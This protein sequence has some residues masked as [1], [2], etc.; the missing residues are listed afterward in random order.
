MTA[1]LEEAA[2]RAMAALPAD[3][4]EVLRLRQEE[5]LSLG[6]AAKRMGRSKEA[7][8]KLYSRA[9]ARLAERLDL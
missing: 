9:L 6:E 5:H 2:R 7:A 4:G 1:E 8:R 3:Y